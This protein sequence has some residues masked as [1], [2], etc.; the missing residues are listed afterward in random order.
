MYACKR[1]RVCVKTIVLIVGGV[2]FLTVVTVV[3]FCYY[4]KRKQNGRKRRRGGVLGWLRDDRR[5]NVDDPATP[6]HRE[7]PAASGLT[8][9]DPCSREAIPLR[10]DN[11]VKNPIYFSPTESHLNATGCRLDAF[12]M[13][14]HSPAS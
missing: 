10:S 3:V 14:F 5:S 6:R 9:A 7:H 8:A 4:R 2:A 13:I 11:I 12:T 1:A